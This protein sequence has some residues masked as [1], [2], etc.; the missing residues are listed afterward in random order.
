MAD[1]A[2]AAVRAASAR[3]DD[4]SSSSSTVAAAAAV[5]LSAEE[6]VLAERVAQLVRVGSAGA[7]C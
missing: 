1:N 2:D 3:T 7:E 5:E 6:R 4:S